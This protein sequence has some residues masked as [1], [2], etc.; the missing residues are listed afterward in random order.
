VPGIA[1]SVLL[2]LLSIAWLAVVIVVVA[3]C[4]A[5][6]RGEQA[7]QCTADRHG[8]ASGEGPPVW[9]AVAVRVLLGRGRA[10]LQLHA[11]RR[12]GSSAHAAPAPRRIS[13]NVR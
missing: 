4:Q 1:N 3:A 13:H 5:A 9:D 7:L 10:P 2:L 12:H 6:A 11:G 8:D